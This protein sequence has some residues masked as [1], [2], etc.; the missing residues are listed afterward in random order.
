M[1]WRA[2]YMGL[3]VGMDALENKNYF[4]PPPAIESRVLRRPVCSLVTIVSEILR[5]INRRQQW[6]LGQGWEVLVCH[7]RM[8]HCPDCRGNANRLAD[9]SCWFYTCTLRDLEALMC[10][11]TT[12]PNFWG[13]GW[14]WVSVGRVL[15]VPMHAG[16]DRPFVPPH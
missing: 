2:S 12:V 11:R 4:F 6:L 5:L 13:T 15:A 3:W 10:T 8:T 14:T 1:H 16:L 7:V 9:K